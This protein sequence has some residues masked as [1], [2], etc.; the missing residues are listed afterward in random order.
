MKI[1]LSL[2][3]SVFTL[4]IVSS[5]RSEIVCTDQQNGKEPICVD[6]GNPPPKQPIVKPGNGCGSNSKC[7]GN[8]IVISESLKG[9]SKKKNA[10]KDLRKLP[11]D[12]LDKT[13]PSATHK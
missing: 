10:K 13:E 8:S 1:W 9:A 4:C 12:I 3:L 7:G 6:V 11:K 5:A 2:G